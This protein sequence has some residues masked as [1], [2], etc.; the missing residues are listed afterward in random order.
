MER[1][2]IIIRMIPWMVISFVVFFAV[3]AVNLI[4][5]YMMSR[6][7]DVAIPSRDLRK[8]ILSVLLYVSVPLLSGI[9][10]SFYVY[11]TAIRCR[12]YSYRFNRRILEKLLR[13][14]MTFLN[15]NS[16]VELSAKAMQ[17][18]SDYV[19]L[20]IC[21][22]PQAAASVLTG[23][24][25]ISIIGSI[26]IYVAAVQLL[27]IVTLV[28]PVRFGGKLVKKNSERLFGAIVR[29][30]AI[31]SEAFNGIRAIK[32]MGLENKILNRYG[33]TYEESNSVFGKAVAVETVVTGGIRD[34]LCAVFL[35][36]AFIQCAVYVSVGSLSM[37]LLVTCISM[38]PRFYS[39]VTSLV[40][41]DLSFKKQMGQYDEVLS[42][43]ELETENKGGVIPKEFLFKSIRLKSVDFSYSDN[44]KVLDRMNLEIEKGSWVGI[45][46]RSGA[47]KSTIIDLLLRLYEPDAGTFEMDGISVPD[48]D[49][50]WYRNHI[51]YVAQEPFLFNGTIRDN[52]ELICGKVDQKELDEALKGV[53]LLDFITQLPDGIDT[54]IGDNGVAISGGEKQRLAVAIA[55]LTKRPLLLL[56]ESTSN[57]DSESER[58][59]RE[60]IRA[61]QNE[62]Q[63][64]IVSVS[65]RKDFHLCTDHIYKME[66]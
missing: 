55:M 66:E 50:L 41:A 12:K 44:K 8:I 10:N 30:R 47:G 27:F 59:V 54:F 18:L 13:Q 11:I 31:V 63:L 14:N 38:L 49:L 16:G 1:Q 17:E 9:G 64:S 56:D 21:T 40:G 43:M 51:A 42:Y 26:N 4:P 57:M 52:I 7:I 61:K 20:W 58:C 15:N 33:K 36:I 2:K 60:F 46:G 19:Y 65:H 5:S 23:L 22:I 37:G 28:L 62:G 24:V 35:G 29:G 48:I 34:F 39:A 45:E 25:T 53:N 3:Q 6:V 32:T